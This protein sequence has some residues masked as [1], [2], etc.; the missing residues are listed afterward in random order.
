MHP[1]ALL[2][3]LRRDP[4][5]KDQKLTKKTLL[6]ILGFARPHRRVITA[7][8]IFVAIDAMLVIVNPLLVRH[9][10]DDGILHPNLSI[11]IWLAVL[12]ALVSVFDAI[13]GVTIGYLS[14]HIG[15]G[16]IFDLRKRVFGHIQR[17]PMAF[18]TRTQT[19]A[20]VSRLNN[21]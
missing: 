20:L 7:F 5:V 15:E 13:L 11:V 10:I 6:R 2:Q 17:M 9:L 14:A 8:L 12:M 16:L 4:S 19:G 21:D 3:S 1:G 18:F